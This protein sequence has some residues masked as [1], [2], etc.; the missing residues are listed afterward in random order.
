MIGV[1]FDKGSGALRSDDASPGGGAAV[2]RKPAHVPVRGRRFVATVPPQEM[3]SRPCAL[4]GA[5]RGSRRRREFRSSS[6]SDPAPVFAERG[7][8]RLADGDSRRFPN[9]RFS[10]V[11]WMRRNHVP[12]VRK[13]SPV[14]RGDAACEM[15]V[16]QSHLSIRVFNVCSPCRTSRERFRFV[17]WRVGDR[18]TDRTGAVR[19]SSFSTLR[20]RTATSFSPS[21]RMTRF[22]WWA[23][24]S[25]VSPNCSPIISS[26]VETMQR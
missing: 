23:R 12:A 6:G 25:G 8:I 13:A 10:A 11:T 20:A 17:D 15:L 1:R 22:A 3:T 24:A 14:I 19:S 16:K 9:A 5:G 18:G 7:A 21:R 4:D 26:R 2:R